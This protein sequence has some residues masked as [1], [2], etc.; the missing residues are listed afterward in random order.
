MLVRSGKDL[1]DYPAHL[2][3]DVGLLLFSLA[4]KD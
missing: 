2:V 3:S 4:L 1:L